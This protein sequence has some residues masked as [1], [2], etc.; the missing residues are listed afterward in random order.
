M[1]KIVRLRSPRVTPLEVW[2]IKFD[3]AP[4]WTSLGAISVQRRF[5]DGEQP[6][7]L[8]RS[9]AES[10][11]RFGRRLQRGE[12]GLLNKG[13]EQLW[14]CGG[15][16]RLSGFRQVI[17]ACDIGVGLIDVGLIEED[18][19]V[20]AGAR[21]FA[22]E[23]GGQGQEPER[24]ILVVDVGQT[25]IKTGVLTINGQIESFQRMPR[26]WDR[27]PIWL[28]SRGEWQDARKPLRSDAE[29][30]ERVIEFIADAIKEQLNG[31]NAAVSSLVLA[32]PC[33]LGRD[34]KP[35]ACSYGDWA[36]APDMIARIVDA[37]GLS[38]KSLSVLPLNDAELAGYAVLDR[39]ETTYPGDSALVLTLGY[40]P[41]AACV[42]S[43]ARND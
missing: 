36:M 12:F 10:A 29:Q 21:R 17:E 22:R 14:L 11:L 37:G 5:D 3:G 2:N 15:L 41:G 38:R 19:E 18:R 30:L 7:E 16:T 27:L 40:G 42:N 28:S 43:E 34:L 6:D 35:G 33:E 31:L 13:C 25:A 1:S 26:P 4:V 8:G 32:L 20:L 24:P 9:V 39:L 23:F